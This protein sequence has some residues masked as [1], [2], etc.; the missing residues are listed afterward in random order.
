MSY[1]VSTVA[2]YLAG[3]TVNASFLVEFDFADQTVRLW[4]GLG[5]L[6]AGGQTW[7]G[8]GQLGSISGIES[9]IGDAAPQV[10][11]GLS[12]VDPSLVA[13]ALADSANVKGRN[14]PVF[15]QFFDGAMQT[16]N[17]PYSIYAGIMDVTKIKADGPATRTI[18][19]TSETLF[20]RRGVPPWGYLS[21]SS[22]RGLYP[23]DAGLDMM[24]QMQNISTG[25][26]WL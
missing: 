2:A 15:L 20:T 5:D 1:F 14:V 4:P 23:G 24:T 6:Y 9:A 11:F 19:L 22:Q 13:E 18:E 8:I 25:W 16:L 21:A 7:A 10:T 17:V 3:Q 26:P 12:G